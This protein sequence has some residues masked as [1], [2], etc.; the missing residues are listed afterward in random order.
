MA[1]KHTQFL[2]TLGTALPFKGKMNMLRHRIVA[3]HRRLVYT[4]MPNLTAPFVTVVV[5]RW[6][7]RLDI[8]TTPG[9]SGECPMPEFL[10]ATHLDEPLH[11]HQLADLQ[12]RA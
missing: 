8:R 2:L 4:V 6:L 10:E 5:D 12:M 3:N 7:T 11:P 9:A 1:E